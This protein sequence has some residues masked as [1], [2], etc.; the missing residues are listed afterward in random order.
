[1]KIGSKPPN[2]A[3]TVTI[4]SNTLSGFN[5]ALDVYDYC[6]N[7]QFYANSL[8]VIGFTSGHASVS[9]FALIQANN[10]FSAIP[11]NDESVTT[12]VISYG[13]WPKYKPYY[14]RFGHALCLQD[15]TA[16]RIPSSAVMQIDNTQNQFGENI[17]VLMSES[18]LNCVIVTNGTTAS[19]YWNGS[20]WMTTAKALAPPTNLRLLN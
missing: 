14:M 7:I 4:C 8:N 2:N 18:S 16:A 5:Y 13:D 9:Q 10:V 3:D 12:N 6:T 1:M 15:S 20:Y 19:F 17:K 11:Q